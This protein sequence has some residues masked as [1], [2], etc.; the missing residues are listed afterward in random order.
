MSRSISSRYGTH[1][2]TGA[3][4]RGMEDALG[5]KDGIPG[6]EKLPAG[7]TAHHTAIDRNPLVQ[8]ARDAFDTGLSTRDEDARL[9]AFVSGQERHWGGQLTELK[10]GKQLSGADYQRFLAEKAIALTRFD[11]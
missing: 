11:R 1:A 4:I 10:P 3:L 6:N 9:S 8:R 5:N 7:S 2:Q